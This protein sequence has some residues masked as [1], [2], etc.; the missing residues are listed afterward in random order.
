MG[1]MYKTGADFTNCFRALSKF[2]SEG[3]VRAVVEYLLDQC[4]SAM[5]YKA[6]FAPTMDPR[7]LEML[8]MLSQQNPDLLSMLGKQAGALERELELA[9]RAGDMKDLDNEKKRKNDVKAWT[10][11]LS[12]YNQRL[13]AEFSGRIPMKC[14]SDALR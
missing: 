13:K 12:S 14:E 11:W 8:M 5:E 4:C 10:E 2:H 6:A 3:D 9:S 7:Q 1:T